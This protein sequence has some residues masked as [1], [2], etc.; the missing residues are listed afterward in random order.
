[1][2]NVTPGEGQADCHLLEMPD[3]GKILI[4]AGDA[5]D[6]LGLCASKLQQLGV[7]HLALVVISHFHYDH[8]RA[9]RDIIKAGI[10]VDKVALN[11]PNK[12][13]ADLEIPW[14]CNLADVEALL[15]ELRSHNIPYFTPKA[16]DSLYKFKSSDGTI[17]GIDVLVVFDGLHSPLGLTDVNDTSIIL[18][19]YYGKTRALFTGDMNFHLGAYL[20]NSDLDLRADIL[21][22][23]HHGTAGLAPDSF[24][25]RVNPHA[26]LIPSPTA[27][28]RSIRS[29]RLRNY[30]IEHK[31]PFFVSGLNG[32]VIATL[33]ETGY[34]VEPEH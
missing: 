14:G 1:M 34:L 29:I 11:V 3:G 4:D 13:S 24:F 6:R 30:C 22:A 28:W 12:R 8:Y 17:V 16:G 7:K 2:L 15:A 18:R 31:I 20:A 21:K 9:L 19:V 33:T 10:V 27:L 5:S 32:D 23:P 26:V 25:D